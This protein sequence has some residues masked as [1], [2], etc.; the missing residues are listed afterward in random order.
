MPR[1]TLPPGLIEKPNGRILAQAYDPHTRKRI[2]KVFDSV[3]A[4]K[5]WKRDT[6]SALEKGQ[7]RVGE[8]PSL[9]T[10]ASEFMLGAGGGTIRS[11]S[12]ERYRPSTLRGY[13]FSLDK[14]LPET[15]KEAA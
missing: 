9:K 11:R 13:K 5:R 3:A 7:I 4:A 2:G 15:V 8:S 14:V 6:E 1:T 12:R 10:A